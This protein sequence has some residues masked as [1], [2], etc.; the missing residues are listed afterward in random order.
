ME[1]Q[2]ETGMGGMADAEV[3]GH[4]GAVKIQYSKAGRHGAR[5]DTAGDS[6]VF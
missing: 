1:K 4:T 5:L 3:L 2:K 6:F